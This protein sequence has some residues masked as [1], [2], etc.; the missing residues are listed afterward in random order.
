M[1]KRI[2]VYKIERDTRRL[3]GGWWFYLW[4]KQDGRPVR[5]SGFGD[6][7]LA[8]FTNTQR[9]WEGQGYEI[10]LGGEEDAH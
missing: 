9:H 10:T 1:N 3:R 2:V 7:E 4:Y 8:A 5:M 6:D